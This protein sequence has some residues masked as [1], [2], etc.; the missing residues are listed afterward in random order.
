MPVQA[1]VSVATHSAVVG[2]G[3]AVGGPVGGVVA[4]TALTAIQLGLGAQAARD[5][6]SELG[7]AIQEGNAEQ[8]GRS[9]ILTTRDMIMLGK[10]VNSGKKLFSGSR[11]L[12]HNYHQ[13][14]LIDSKKYQNETK[15]FQK[16]STQEIKIKKFYPQ[17]AETQNR[18][19]EYH[20][21]SEIQ[22]EKLKSSLKSDE[23]TSIVG[24]SGHGLQR[25]LER[26]FSANDLSSLINAPDI[27]KIQSD[28]ARVYIKE[29]GNNKYNFLV[30]NNKKDKVI[31]AIKNITTQD[32]INLSKNYGWEL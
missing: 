25:L 16:K 1:A 28:G 32:I 10:S 11:P 18:T 4:E 23:F 12:K 27:I 29:M 21:S 20:P 6:I 26:G 7:R 9:A 14:A 8:V 17:L 24:I 30:Y 15:N 2:V 19:K 22:Y 3:T 13:L 31:T 5:N